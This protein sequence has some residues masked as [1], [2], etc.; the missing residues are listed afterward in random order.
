MRG[1]VF[2]MAVRRTPGEG[3]LVAVDGSGRVNPKRLDI[4][5]FSDRLGVMQQI[6]ADR[7]GDA[8]PR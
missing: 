8:Q 1:D 2:V 4:S 6:A 5:G 7:R 3:E